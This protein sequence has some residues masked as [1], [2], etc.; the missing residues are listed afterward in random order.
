MYMVYRD[1]Y[2]LWMKACKGFCQWCWYG[3]V[4]HNFIVL[5]FLQSP[6]WH[7]SPSKWWLWY[8]LREQTLRIGIAEADGHHE[9]DVHFAF[10]GGHEYNVHFAFHEECC[11]RK[12][13]VSN[14]KRKWKGLEKCPKWFVTVTV[15]IIFMVFKD[16]VD[17]NVDH[18]QVKIGST[19]VGFY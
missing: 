2:C 9:Y 16:H 5:H 14:E 15:I 6:L 4:Q 13:V 11:W 19:V 17:Y 8:S 12:N 10:H 7:S 18:K 1:S 3:G